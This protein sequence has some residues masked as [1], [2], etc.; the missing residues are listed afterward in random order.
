VYGHSYVVL[1]W[2]AEDPGLNYARYGEKIKQVAG[3]KTVHKLPVKHFLQEDQLE[4][5]AGHITTIAG[6]K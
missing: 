2:G 6:K 4:A 3:L 1:D 5:V